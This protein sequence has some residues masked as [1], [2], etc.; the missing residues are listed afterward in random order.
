MLLKN[1]FQGE[2]DLKADEL[3]VVGLTI[4]VSV[5]REANGGLC[6]C[7]ATAPAIADGQNT[8]S[9]AGQDRRSPDPA[10]HLTHEA[11]YDGTHWDED[12]GNM[13]LQY[14]TNFL[15]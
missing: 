11:H 10:A 7:S 13:H 3:K 14:Q 9:P 4:D 6:L 15:M 1:N 8:H 5:L 2:P 12:K